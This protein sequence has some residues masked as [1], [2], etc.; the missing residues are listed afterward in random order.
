MK[1][2]FVNAEHKKHDVT[3]QNQ[4][5]KVHKTGLASKVVD[6]LLT[7]N[8]LIEVSSPTAENRYNHLKLTATGKSTLAYLEARLGSRKTI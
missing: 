7:I 5:R 3:L 8:G 2:D 1:I 4:L 6:E